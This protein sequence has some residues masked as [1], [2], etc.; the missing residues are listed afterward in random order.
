[1]SMLSQILKVQNSGKLICICLN[2]ID[3]NSRII[4]YVKGININKFEFQVIDEFGQRK[5]KRA[6]LLNMVKSLE[7][8]GIYNNM[9]EKLV[10]NGYVKGKTT[11]KYLYSNKNRFRENICKLIDSKEVCTFFFKTEFS[12]G[13]VTKVS[14]SELTIKNISYEGVNDGISIFDLKQLTKVRTRSHLENRIKFLY[15]LT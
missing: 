7:I 12:I 3:W 15:T 5:G 11:P 4:G 13:I 1:M 2:S 14:K 10:K 8:G 9:L 6:I